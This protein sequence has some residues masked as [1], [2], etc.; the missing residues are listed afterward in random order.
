MKA[1][2][3]C[4]QC[5]Q[6]LLVR[7]ELGLACDECSFELPIEEVVQAA[8]KA[9]TEVGEYKFKAKKIAIVL[10]DPEEAEQFLRGLILARQN[11]SSSFFPDL[12]D[13]VN[14][15]LE[16]WREHTLKAQLLQRGV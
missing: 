10:D 5:N 3:K 12:I 11:N 14:A 8:E 1:G 16:P 9:K 4:P 13:S 2:D 6:G 15:V 7:T